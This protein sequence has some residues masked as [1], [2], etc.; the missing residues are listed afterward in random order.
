MCMKRVVNHEDGRGGKEQQTP[1][2]PTVS[3][4]APIRCLP[5]ESLEE[6][7]HHTSGLGDRVRDMFLQRS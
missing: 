5:G 4:P 1:C 3:L 6:G 7:L 2:R